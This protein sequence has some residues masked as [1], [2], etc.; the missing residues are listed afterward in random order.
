MSIQ[1]VRSFT[2]VVACIL[3]A[4]LLFFFHPVTAFAEHWPQWRGPG[5][6]GITNEAGLPT[7]WS[8][9]TNVAWRV[10]LPESGNSSPVVWGDRIFVTQPIS[11]E[12]M[13]TVICFRKSDGKQLWQQGVKYD[14]EEAS[15]RTNPY[16]SPSPVTDGERV[17]VW[18]G[19]A[20]LV[21]YDM[22]GTRL[23]QKDLGPLEHMWGYGTSP[24]LHEDLC[25]LNFGPGANEALL[26]LNKTNGEE[27]W[28]VAPLDVTEELELSGPENDGNVD[29][30][31]DKSD[32][33]KKLRGAWGTPVV[34]KVGDQT[35]LIVAHPRR[36]SAYDPASGKLRWTCGGSAPLAYV[37]PMRSENTFLT[38]GGYFG[39]SIAVDGDGEG[40]VTDT[41]RVWHKERESTN[42]LGTGVVRDGHLYIC[43]MKGVAHCF[44]CAT[45]EIRWKERLPGSSG[46]CWSSMTMTGDGVIYL[47][48]QKGDVFV[49][50]ASPDGYE[51][52]AKN[53]MEENSNST[54]A[55]SNGQL[56]IRTFDAL[57]CI[58]S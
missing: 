41:K 2:L 7:T 25:I 12:N 57:W 30:A 33:D 47:M 8:R 17:I 1:S 20:G 18:F 27:V 29:P 32:L 9:E 19:S 56:I 37:T 42:W 38:L 48:S 39:G 54:V 28:R 35:H 49:F 43:D 53:Q 40:D 3:P 23:W 52:I 6:N 14:Q 11:A 24:I 34:E 22:D 31:R 50:R 55:V 4:T 36:M 15:H 46:E 45:G 16:C 44:D 58:G 51:A 10:E 26:A 5:G 13:R 21:C